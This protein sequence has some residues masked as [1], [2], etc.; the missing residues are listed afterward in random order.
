LSGHVLTTF[1][2]LDVFAER[3]PWAMTKSCPYENE[4]KPILV[5]KFTVYG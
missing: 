5:S 2:S 4:F 3:L 1:T